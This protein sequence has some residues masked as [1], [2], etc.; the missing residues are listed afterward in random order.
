MATQGWANCTKTQQRWNLHITVDFVHNFTRWLTCH[1]S[2]LTSKIKKPL[3]APK[4]LYFLFPLNIP[5]TIYPLFLQSRH[6]LSL[7]CRFSSHPHTHCLVM[8]FPNG[9]GDFITSGL[10]IGP[11]ATNGQFKT[12]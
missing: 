5:E 4:L 11:V 12:G 9:S 2:T 1:L 8:L 7:S 3:S 10:T 6:N